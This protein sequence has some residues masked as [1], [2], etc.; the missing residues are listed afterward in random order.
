MGLLARAKTGSLSAAA[1]EDRGTGMPK[2]FS[3]FLIATAFATVPIQLASHADAATI[4]DPVAQFSTSQNTN[5]SLWSYRYDS[6]ARDGS[7]NLFPT[8][9]IDPTFFAPP[10]GTWHGVGRYPFVGVNTGSPAVYQ[11][12]PPATWP[13]NTIV[14]H[15]GDTPGTNALVAVSWLSPTTTVVDLTFRFFDIDPNGGNGVS[16][17]V[18]LG[19]ASGEQDS[20]SFANGGDSGVLSVFGVS[21]LAGQR[22]NFVVTSPD[23]NHLFDATGFTATITD[24][25]A[26]PIPAALPLFATGLASMIVLGLRRRKRNQTAAR[27]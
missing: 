10:V 26:V 24:T 14:M 12:G 22:I 6:T 20:G 9:D 16:W 23:G 27:P 19:G 7:Y 17:F 18:D 25:S 11:L 21:V 13:S 2:L 8:F 1:F 15:P 3:R 4:Y 5:T